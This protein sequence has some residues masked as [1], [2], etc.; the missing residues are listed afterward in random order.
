MLF[1]L[2]SLKKDFWIAR[3]KP[4]FKP[5][6]NHW[7]KCGTSEKKPICLLE[8]NPPFT[9]ISARRWQQLTYMQGKKNMSTEITKF[10]Q[11]RKEL[12]L[13]CCNVCSQ[14]YLK[15]SLLIGFYRCCIFTRPTGSSKRGTTHKNNNLLLTEREGSTGEYWPGVRTETT[16]GQ[17]SPVRLK[18]ARLVSSLLYG[19]LAML[20]LN[21]PTVENKKMHSRWMFPWKRSVWRSPHQERTSQNARIHLGI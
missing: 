12:F 21:L 15:F 13:I 3:Q 9:N 17:Y 1:F 5:N 20:A 10:A 11:K 14:Y 7:K 8:S 4:I 18:L 6:W 19:T 2:F 16:E